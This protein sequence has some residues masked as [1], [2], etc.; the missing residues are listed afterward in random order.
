MSLTF[1]DSSN[2]LTEALAI[3]PRRYLAPF[4]DVTRRFIFEEDYI[5]LRASYS[6]PT[7]DAPHSG[8][9]GYYLVDETG[10]QPFG[11]SEVL[12]F[13]RTYSEVPPSRIIYESFDWYLP[14]VG[15]ENPPGSLV[16][17]TDYSFNSNGTQL[18]LSADPGVIIGDTVQASYTV[19]TPTGQVTRTVLRPVILDSSATDITVGLISEI[20]PITFQ[21]LRKVDPG[22][23]PEARAVSSE[24]HFDYFLPGL[25]AGIAT[26]NSIGIID[27]LEIYD[28]TGRKTPSFTETT[29]PTRAEWAA[30]VASRERVVVERSVIRRWMGNIY[31]RATRYATA[32]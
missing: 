20:Y 18:T 6:S 12:K 4:P 2:G 24:I 17:I 29:S 15:S 25:S 22:R 26:P 11:N 9:S 30:K 32:I 5:V 7:L 27:D 19:Q 14:G 8:V 13:T 21:T 28:A 31:E 3:G 16:N 10:P 1:N 23:N